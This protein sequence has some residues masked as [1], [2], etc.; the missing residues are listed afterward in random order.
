[1]RHALGLCLIRTLETDLHEALSHY[2]TERVL[3]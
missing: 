1:V 2:L 3:K